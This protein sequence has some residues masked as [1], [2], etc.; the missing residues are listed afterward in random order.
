MKPE[1]TLCGI[2]FDAVSIK[3]S[4]H[5]DQPKDLVVRREDFGEFG[6]TDKEANHALVFMVKGLAT[7]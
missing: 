7:K 2:V 1:Q 4:L 6:G 3:P 5:Y